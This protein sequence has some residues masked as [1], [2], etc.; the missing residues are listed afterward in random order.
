MV[1]L[2]W[3]DCDSEEVVSQLP[4]SI[5]GSTSPSPEE[6]ILMNTQR[7]NGHSRSGAGTGRTNAGI[8]TNRDPIKLLQTEPE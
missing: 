8:P 2:E 3:R 6:G 4:P 5:F 1:L 7:R